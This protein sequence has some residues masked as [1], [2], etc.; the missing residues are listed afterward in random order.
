MFRC[1]FLYHIKNPICDPLPK[2]LRNIKDVFSIF[3]NIFLL[4]VRKENSTH[5]T[6]PDLC[7]FSW[8]CGSLKVTP[9]EK[10]YMRNIICVILC[11]FSISSSGTGIKNISAV[12]SLIVSGKGK[13]LVGREPG[14]VGSG[15]IFKIFLNGMEIGMTGEGETV[16]GDLAPGLNIV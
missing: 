3:S 13:L 1:R 4:M 5:H 6:L 10:F 12:D 8:Q 16:I 7:R 2:V 11:S 15:Q 14:L 9:E